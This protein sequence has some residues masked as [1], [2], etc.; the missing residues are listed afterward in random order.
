M[1]SAKPL[2]A[3]ILLFALLGTSAVRA[4][5]TAGEL[6]PR[7][8]KADGGLQKRGQLTAHSSS[9]A[10]TYVGDLAVVLA[11]QGR[12]EVSDASRADLD[13]LHFSDALA[14]KTA[15]DNLA[16]ACPPKFETFEGNVWAVDTPYRCQSAPYLLHDALWGGVG[17]KL[18]N[19]IVAA[20]PTFDGPI[21]FV[22]ADD[23]VAI[24]RLSRLVRTEQG[25]STARPLSQHL[26]LYRAGVW[27]MFERGATR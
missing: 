6:L 20:L 13:R 11:F 16:R 25:R 9:A 24:D 18:A 15:L 19:G 1:Y 23:P 26:Y 22:P 27:E 17:Q 21:F 12:S 8:V 4:E 5:G 7:M 10:F 14:V 3:S 2:I